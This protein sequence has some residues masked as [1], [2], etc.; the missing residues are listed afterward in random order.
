MVFNERGTMGELLAERIRHSEDLLALENN[1]KEFKV[2]PQYKEMQ[3]E[4]NDLTDKIHQLLNKIN[5][6]ERILREYE[7]S[8]AI[9]KDVSAQKVRDLY[10]NAGVSFPKEL[11]RSLEEVEHFHTVIVSNRKEYLQNEEVRLKDTIT[12]RR[13]EIELLSSRRAVAMKL[14]QSH[15]ALE[16]YDA[17]LEKKAT[18]REK[19]ERVKSAIANLSAFEDGKSALKIEQEELLKKARMDKVERS[20]TVDKAIS[21]F[22]KNSTVLYERPGVLAVDVQ[23]SGYT[24]N[25]EIERS[26]SQGIN[27][28]KVFCYDLTLSQLWSE[29]IKDHVLIHDSTIFDGVDE[30]Q[31][32]RSLEL[33]ASEAEQKGFQYICT[34]NSDD[35]PNGEFSSEFKKK[36]DSSVRL[37]L[38]DK[39]PEQSLLGFRF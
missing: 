6:D 31:T 8:V 33:A 10:S 35:V 26:G 20:A 28:M 36:F 22:N 29:V 34:L 37:T 3:K 32:A 7:K 9:E 27:Y 16:E 21:L 38:T 19:L 4:A 18:I 2:H 39:E 13:N 1:I 11:I 25:I 24:Y 15:G 17:L 14:L 12:K 30:R 23:K 5:I